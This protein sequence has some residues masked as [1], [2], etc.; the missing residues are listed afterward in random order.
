MEKK[1][2]V[3]QHSLM[4]YLPSLVTKNIVDGLLNK[5]SDL[6]I[7]YSMNSVCLMADISG[8]TMLSETYSAMGRIGAEVLAFMLNRYMEQMSIYIFPLYKFYSKNNLIAYLIL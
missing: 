8:F 1:L 4:G 5:I 3:G 7:Y 6:P 2:N